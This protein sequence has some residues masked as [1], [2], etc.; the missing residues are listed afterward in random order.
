MLVFKQDWPLRLNN[1]PSGSPEFHRDGG[2]TEDKCKK[3][4]NANNVR[5]EQQGNESKTL[6]TLK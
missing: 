2:K 3:K 6:R 5:E 1:R 4:K